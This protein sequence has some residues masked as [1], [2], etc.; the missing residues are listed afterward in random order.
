MRG[1]KW[2][3][4]GGSPGSW[5][6]AV[7]DTGR[8]HP[9]ADQASSVIECTRRIFVASSIQQSQVGGESDQEPQLLNPQVS[10]TQS[11]CT[12]PRVGGFDQRFEH[13][14]GDALDPI[15]KREL[16]ASREFLD[17]REEP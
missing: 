11:F 12:I 5:G 8:L 3:C 10:S 17:G 4:R 14:Q 15:A 7:C 13:V 1:K 2:S 6:R 9:A 16:V